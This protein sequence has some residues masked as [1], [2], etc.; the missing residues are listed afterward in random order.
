ME[1]IERHDKE[2]LRGRAD[3]LF[4][5]SECRTR[6]DQKT[7]G[8]AMQEICDVGFFDRALTPDGYA[9]RPSKRW[10]SF[11]E[12]ADLERTRDIKARKVQRDRERRIAY[13]N[14]ARKSSRRR[15]VKFP[16]RSTGKFSG[17]LVDR[18]KEDLV[19][20]QNF[21]SPDNNNRK[22][23][24]TLKESQPESNPL[25]DEYIRDYKN[26]SWPGEEDD[27]PF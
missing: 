1:V 7:F 12:A 13:Q 22:E 26:L 27:I 18:R 14:Q 10:G 16:G 11:T 25:Y 17:D 5:W 6:C 19:L 9:Y 24:T 2:A 15:Q 3:F 8:R 23:T 20:D 21:S 4:P